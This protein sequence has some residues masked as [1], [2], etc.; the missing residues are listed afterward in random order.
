MATLA[1]TIGI[2]YG[3]IIQNIPSEEKSLYSV[4]FI[5]LYMGSICIDFSGYRLSWTKGT[6]K[7]RNHED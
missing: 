2:L 5:L 4:F 6:P 1:I 7:N 3:A